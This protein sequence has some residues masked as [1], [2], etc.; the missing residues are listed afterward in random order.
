MASG[1]STLLETV[2]EA[3]QSIVRKQPSRERIEILLCLSL[4]VVSQGLRLLVPLYPGMDL[5]FSNRQ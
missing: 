2:M 1:P 4:A 5:A 3:N